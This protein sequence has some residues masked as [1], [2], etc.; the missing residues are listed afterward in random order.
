MSKALIPIFLI[1]VV[2][3][4]GMAIIFPLLPFYAEHL[5][6]TPAQAGMLVSTFAVCQ[7]IGGPMLGRMSDTMGRKPLLIL[8]QAG[9]LAGFCI[10]AWGKTLPLIFLSR[11]IDGF[12]AGNI[13]LAQ[14]YIADVTRPEERTRS[15][16]VIGIAFGVGFL[17]GPAI[18]GFLSQ[19]SY[20]AP[21]YLAMALSALSIVTTQLLLPVTR[22]SAEGTDDARR[23]TILDWRTY[24]EYFRRPGLGSLLWQF[25]AFIF[26]FSAFMTGFPLFAER[27]FTWDGK[28]FGPREVGYVYAYVGV[29]AVL[30]QGGFIGRLVRI[31]GDAGLVRWGFML[32]VIGF[33]ALGWTFG[34]G[35]MLITAAAVS[36][37]TG[38]LRPALT[39]LITQ[40]AGRGEQGGVLGL[41]QSLQSVASIVAPAL[42]GWLIGHGA[43]AG[44]ACV[45]AGSM[46][47]GLILNRR[48]AGQQP[49][50]APGS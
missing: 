25:F 34:I 46:G 20:E 7:L 36:V 13:S 24:V 39:S 47:I 8:S 14:A 17:I 11:A 22:A 48:S 4:L 19:I 15:F 2:D 26:A 28:A 1:I 6:A 23:F 37:S 5:G 27:R 18:G 38:V 3:I 43:L 45:A 42:S 29:L 50:I 35:P 9:T 40:H 12:T 16:A 44:W 10:L 33:A 30:L 21:V 49:P 31:F 41:T 32:A